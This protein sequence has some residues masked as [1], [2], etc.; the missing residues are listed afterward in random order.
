MTL[1]VH[2]LVAQKR[3][4]FLLCDL[5]EIFQW[6]FESFQSMRAEDTVKVCEIAAFIQPI[7]LIFC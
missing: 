7:P 6:P 2:A 1:F 3:H 5:D 4:D